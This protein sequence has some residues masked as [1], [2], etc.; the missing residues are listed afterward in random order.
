MS[1]VLHFLSA[2][3]PVLYL[4]NFHQYRFL[5]VLPEI[6]E[7]PIVFLF[8]QVFLK[9]IIVDAKF[10]KGKIVMILRHQKYG[11]LGIIYIHTYIHILFHHFLLFPEINSI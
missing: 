10:T 1:R 11:V 9:Q 2:V 3:S 7:N 5:V 6:A 4:V 8:V